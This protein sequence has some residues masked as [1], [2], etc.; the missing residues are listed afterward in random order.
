[1]ATTRI[2]STLA[3]RYGSAA[4]KIFQV[5]GD[6]AG[7]VFP[8]EC[9]EALHGLVNF[10]AL[11][12]TG[13]GQPMVDHRDLLTEVLDQESVRQRER[14]EPGEIPLEKVGELAEQYCSTLT[15]LRSGRVQDTTTEDRERLA[16]FLEALDQVGSCC[17]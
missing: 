3:A 11:V 10:L 9:A 1:M 7:G 17:H 2:S 16:I 4:G 12:I 15:L 13:Q 6:Y 5:L 14:L 8:P